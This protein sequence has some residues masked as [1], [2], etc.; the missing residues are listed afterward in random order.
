MTNL[1][2]QKVLDI[3][4]VVA[5]VV[6]GALL[7]A[8]DTGGGLR[9]THQIWLSIVLAES[10]VALLFRRRRPVGAL[11]GVLTT[12]VLFDAP[13]VS[14]LPLLVA[15]FTV[16]S[17]SPRR[18]GVAAAAVCVVAVAATALLHDGGFNVGHQGLV[19]LTALALA[20]VS[21]L[22]LRPRLTAT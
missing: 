6:V 5:V 11:A 18:T 2:R 10:A 17:S 21:G 1:T 16:V 22:R 20:Y 15:L 14:L 19:P 8:F 3:A 7:I 13:A 9:S 4:P 12:F